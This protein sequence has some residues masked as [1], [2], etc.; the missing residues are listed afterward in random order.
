MRFPRIPGRG[1]LP[2]G[3]ESQAVF[4]FVE[5]T[6]EV[7]VEIEAATPAGVLEE[8]VRAFGALVGRG[9][10]GER[11]IRRVSVDGPDLAILLPALVDELV[12]LVDTDG[13][14]PVDAR[15]EVDGTHAVATVEGLLDEPAPLV[16]AA[17]LHRLSFEPSDGGWRARLVLDV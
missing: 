12:Y 3:L 2:R 8:S 1:I 4:R 7:E 11:A 16:K 10:A 17:T 15:A 14:V 13:F 5:H 9:Q 6:G